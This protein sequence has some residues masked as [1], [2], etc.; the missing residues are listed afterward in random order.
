M[1]VLLDYQMLGHLT[2]RGT[3]FYSFIGIKVFVVVGHV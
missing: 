3:K 2:K 1:A